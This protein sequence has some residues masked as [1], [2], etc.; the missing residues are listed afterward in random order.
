MKTTTAAKLKIIPGRG[1]SG[2]DIK[3]RL[4]NRTLEGQTFGAEAY[5]LDENMN[6]FLKMS[7]VQQRNAI[8]ANGEK[9]REIQKELEGVDNARKQRQQ[10]QE[11][12]RKV[13]ERMKE[14]GKEQFK[15]DQNKNNEKL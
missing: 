13:Q 10:E 15:K 7:T 4:R 2:R 5:T 6:E 14:I 1:L 3:N 11:I 12:E 9:I 8:K